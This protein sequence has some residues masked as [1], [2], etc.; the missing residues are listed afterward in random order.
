MKPMN[1]GVKHHSSFD[2]DNF[3]VA[4]DVGDDVVVE[5]DSLIDR[6]LNITECCW[7]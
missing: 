5:F 3:E 7:F 1:L 2:M 4:V 6:E